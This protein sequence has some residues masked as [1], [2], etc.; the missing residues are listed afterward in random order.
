MVPSVLGLIEKYLPEFNFPHLRYSF[1]SGDALKQNLAVK[2]K[3]CL[4]NGVIHN[5]YG[6]TET[7][8]VCTRYKW[9]E[10]ISDIESLNNIVPIGKPFPGMHFIVLSEEQKMITEVRTV[11]ELCFLGVQ[12]IDNYLNNSNE[13]SFIYFEGKRYY[14][15]GDLVSLNEKENLIFHGRLD[16]QVKINGYRIE[17]AEIENAILKVCGKLNKVVVNEL[18]QLVA[19]VESDNELDLKGEMNKLLP[20]YMMPICFVFIKEIPL[21]ING[22]IDTQKIQATL[23]AM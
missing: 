5:F 19:F 2:W 4:P 11:G 23:K 3:K 14:K 13:N 8:I 22:K 17:L 7:T 10:E 16:S 6:P 21:S 20:S 15:T 1:F 12:V 9:D 18:N